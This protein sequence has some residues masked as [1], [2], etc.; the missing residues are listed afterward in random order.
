MTTLSE[1]LEILDSIGPVLRFD[2]SDDTATVVYELDEHAMLVLALPAGPGGKA[3]VG[4]QF[5]V[6]GE[7][8]TDIIEFGLSHVD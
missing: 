6:R 7:P 5:F 4:I 8:S 1:K 2:M 3:H